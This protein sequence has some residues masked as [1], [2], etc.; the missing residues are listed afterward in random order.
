[1]N[2]AFELTKQ[3]Q[4]VVFAASKTELQSARSRR[5]RSHDSGGLLLHFLMNFQ[6]DNLQ[7]FTASEL[8]NANEHQA[9]DQREEASQAK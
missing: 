4:F 1:M 8:Q 7:H 3:I 2:V 6:V 9:D 5:Q